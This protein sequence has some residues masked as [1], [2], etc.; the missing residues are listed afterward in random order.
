MSNKDIIF[1]DNENLIPQIKNFIG[2]ILWSGQIFIHWIHNT[3]LINN[4]YIKIDNE[5]IEPFKNLRNCDNSFKIMEKF[6]YSL[7]IQRQQKLKN[8]IKIDFYER[9]AFA[10][11][12]Y[13]YVD[14]KTN[15]VIETN[16][17]NELFINQKKI[18]LIIVKIPDIVD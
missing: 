12:L 2:A 1:R 18:K 7:T 16:N 10:I 17:N 13:F 5:V 3:F 8:M 11:F 9:M 14:S 6:Y 15:V 4:C